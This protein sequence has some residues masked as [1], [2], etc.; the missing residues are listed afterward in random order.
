MH[1]HQDKRCFKGGD[2]H[3]RCMLPELWRVQWLMLNAYSFVSRMPSLSKILSLPCKTVAGPMAVC[4][5][6][7]LRFTALPKVASV[8]TITGVAP[9]HTCSAISC[10]LIHLQLPSLQH[11]TPAKLHMMHADGN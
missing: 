3:A 7:F 8:T 9:Y 6:G 11:H 5:F 4:L 2:V 10:C 1:G